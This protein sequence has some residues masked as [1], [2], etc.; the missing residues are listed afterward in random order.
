MDHD[1]AFMIERWLMQCQRASTKTQLTQILQS[2]V[3]QLDMDYYLMCV[4][5]PQQLKSSDMFVIDN[6]PSDWMSHYV[7]NDLKKNDPVVLHAQ[8]S[9]TPIFWQNANIISTTN[10][11]ADIKIM[12]QAADAGLVDGI[13][14]PIRG[15]FG[16]FGL[17]SIASKELIDLDKYINLNQILLSITP[18]LYE[19]S[20]RLKINNSPANKIELTSRESECMEWVIEGKTA[21]ETAQILGIS[22]RT[23]NFHVNNVIEKTSSSNRQQAIAKLLISGLLKPVI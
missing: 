1:I 18:Y 2:I 14:A 15:M 11:H 12:Q 3:K 8:T 20:N 21:W 13:T 16:E 5:S 17:I 22:E 10:P 9:V 19:A 4:V 6:Y 23:T 7:G